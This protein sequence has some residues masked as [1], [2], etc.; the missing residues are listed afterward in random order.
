MANFTTAANSSSRSGKTW[1]VATT[2]PGKTSIT[3]TGAIS[4]NT[5][6]SDITSSSSNSSSSCR[7]DPTSAGVMEKNHVPDLDTNQGAN[8][9]LMTAA[10]AL[11][12]F[13]GQIRES[14]S[15]HT[16]AAGYPP[17]PPAQHALTSGTFTTPR[18]NMKTAGTSTQQH[19]YQYPPSL[20]LLN[21]D[22][23]DAT[24]PPAPHQQ[25]PLSLPPSFRYHDSRPSKTNMYDIAESHE[26]GDSSIYCYRGGAGAGVEDSSAI[27]PSINNKAHHKQKAKRFPVKL[28]HILSSGIHDHII[29]WTHD[30]LSFVVK[31]PNLLVSEVLPNYFKEV[32]YSSFTRKLHRWG[33]VKLLRGKELSAYFHNEFRRGDYE[34][35][36]QMTCSKNGIG[37]GGLDAM[38]HVLLQ[39]NL[40]P[41]RKIQQERMQQE[42]I[43]HE[44]EQILQEQ[45]VQEKYARDHMNRNN[46]STTATRY[47][48]SDVID[49][50]Y[51]PHHSVVFIPQ[52]SYPVQREP[53]LSSTTPYLDQHPQMFMGYPRLPNAVDAFRNDYRFRG[54]SFFPL[55]NTTIEDLQFEKAR[56]SLEHRRIIDNAMNALKWEQARTSRGA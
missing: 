49:Q 8:D 33:F 37:S 13:S 11:A 9:L 20:L 27:N 48:D 30:G 6:T 14:T 35:C 41:A 53:I 16:G 47:V 31:K 23:H 56:H 21:A 2:S 40:E 10:T 45:M 3:R 4:S 46:N 5:K 32:K 54:S 18:T 55:P 42:R 50:R 34:R 52:Q 29:C 1:F 25:L 44:K 19:D 24:P 12:S 38:S 7:N 39:K 26:H 51:Q 43:Q 28:M 15:R 22:D 17:P 36:A